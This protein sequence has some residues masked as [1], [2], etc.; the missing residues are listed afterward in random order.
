MNKVTSVR[1]D[2]ELCKKLDRL[3]ELEDR[4]RAWLIQQAIARYVEEELP[5]VEAIKEA[6][7]EY[8]S[9]K[10]VLIPHEQVMREMDEFLRAKGL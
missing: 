8:E 1:L 10:A 3:G 5:E 7:D 9:G 2:E 4:P 6:L